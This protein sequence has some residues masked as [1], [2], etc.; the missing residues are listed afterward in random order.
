M[1]V[2]AA[3]ESGKILLMFIVQKGIGSGYHLFVCGAS[4]RKMI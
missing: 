1:C 2:G 4:I 3:I